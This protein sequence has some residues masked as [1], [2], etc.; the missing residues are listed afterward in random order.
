MAFAKISLLLLYR[1]IFDIEQG[2]KIAIWIGIVFIA[3]FYSAYAFLSIGSM[4]LC[5]GLAQLDNSY[6]VFM[7]GIMVAITSFVNVFTDFY[8]LI[9]PIP[10]ILRL[11]LQAR[12]KIGLLFV[13]ASGLA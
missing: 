13:F 7:E 2:L 5:I 8:I 11:R 12:R 3:V 9:L 10:R 6:C 1:R 4:A